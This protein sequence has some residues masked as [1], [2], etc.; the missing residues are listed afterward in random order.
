[1]TELAIGLITSLFSFSCGLLYQKARAMVVSR[2]T[3]EEARRIGEERHPSFTMKWLVEYYFR[4]DLMHELLLVE[5]DQRRNFIPFLTKNSWKV[6]E[7][8]ESGL[9]DQCVP[10]P[11]SDAP[12]KENVLHRRGKYLEGVSGGPEEWNDLLACA[13][14]IEETPNGPR[15][16][17]HLAEYFQYLS[18][19]GSLEDET[20]DAIRR[21]GRKTP[22][23][24]EALSSIAAASQNP[25]GAHGLGMQVAL[26]YGDATEYKILVQ[27]RSNSVA[28]Y[29]G[30][31]AVVPVFGCQTLDIT[32]QTH[33]SFF[34]NFLRE[35]YEELYGGTEVERRGPQVDPTWFY[36]KPPVAR[37]LDYHASGIL[38]FRILGFGID[39]LN[40]EVNVAALALITDSAVAAREIREMRVNWEVQQISAWHLFGE[41]LDVGLTRGDFSPGSAYAIAR[42]REYLAGRR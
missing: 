15:I 9:L 10:H 28:L 35:T 37:L 40:G 11:L 3:S 25:L 39:A 5:T 31:L 33:L 18:S 12:L 32:A 36:S 2:R 13:E 7:A 6:D 34:H 42:A 30:A 8:D 29:G 21:P 14:R 22:I 41:E 27:R 26:V 16:K 4:R 1:M 24:D 19:C 38:S 20:Y 23:R 17:V